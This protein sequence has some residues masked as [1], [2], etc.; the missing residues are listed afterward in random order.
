M[1]K[2]DPKGSALKIG[3]LGAGDRGR[4]YAGYCRSHPAEA[5]VVAVADPSEERLKN[6][7]K[8]H[9]LPPEAGFASW[10][11]LLDRPRGI[12]AVVIAT[13]DRLHVAPALRALELGYEILLEKPIAPTKRE[14]L[15]LAG[16]TARISGNITVA[17]VLRYTPFFARIK[18]LLDDGR[19]GDLVSIQWAENIG[20]W[21]FAHSYVRGN[22]AN[23]AR[24]S[25][26]ILAKSCHDMDMLRWLVGS[27]WNQISSFG[28]LT[29]FRHERAPEGAPERCIEGCPVYETCPFNAVTF[30]ADGLAG[31]DGWPVTIVSEDTGRES[32]LEALRHGPYG[33]CVYR[34]DNDVVDH[35]VVNMAF[36]NGVTATLS[37]C[38][39]TSENTRTLK[40]MGSRGEIRGHLES[41]EIE[42]RTFEAVPRSP[43][44][45][46]AGGDDVLP[47][48]FSSER[49]HVSVEV[50]HAGGD[51]G[52]MRAFVERA[53]R[54]SAGEALEEAATSLVESLDSHFMA[55]AAEESRLGGR[56][57]AADPGTAPD[58]LC[59]GAEPGRL[60]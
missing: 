42:L 41:G 46:V 23:S 50:G 13:P 43:R 59:K 12:D 27:P 44:R 33:R 11:Q 60:E 3:V 25:P 2:G 30:Y 26:M 21:H 37:V 18:E 19:I 58:L 4:Q 53:R 54:A 20:F 57:V 7:S 14:V 36:L 17:H 32:L 16:A 6:F 56:V 40:L 8:A 24:S 1:A 29:L 31:Y 9:D 39:A 22:W 51:E 28:N 52:L 10:E 48:W 5:R 55:F 38:A 45:V 47:M 35:Q 34:C 49:M 15:R